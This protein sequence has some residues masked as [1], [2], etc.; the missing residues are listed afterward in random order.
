MSRENVEIVRRSLVAFNQ[1][2]ADGLIALCTP[3]VEFEPLVAGV[4]GQTYR[5][6]EG[7]RAWLAQM[8]EIFEEYRA[9]HHEIEDLGDVVL[10][11]GVTTGRGRGSGVPIAR[12]WTLGIRFE[13]D[14]A[15]FWAFRETRKGALEA[16][17]LREA[18]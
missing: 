11:R 1:S 8:N 10:V 6:G 5:G 13:G 4:E 3:D 12:P 17:G 18:E 15:V 2:D 7:I 14:K 9:E 16:V